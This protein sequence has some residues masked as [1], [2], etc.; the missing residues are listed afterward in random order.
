MIRVKELPKAHRP[1]TK[2][3]L[4]EAPPMKS[5]QV[6]EVLSGGPATPLAHSQ[7]SMQPP[8]TLTKGRFTV[9]TT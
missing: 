7:T 2:L 1:T 4:P 8:A 3:N 9:A 6:R 5:E